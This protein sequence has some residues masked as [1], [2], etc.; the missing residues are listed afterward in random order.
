MISFSLNINNAKNQI[1]FY[2][3]RTALPN[4]FQALPK[5]SLALPNLFLKIPNF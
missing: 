4:F 3:L 1:Y 5:S 2:I